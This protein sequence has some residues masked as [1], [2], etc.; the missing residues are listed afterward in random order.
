[1]FDEGGYQQ[2]D[3]PVGVLCYQCREQIQK[4]DRGLIRAALYGSKPDF[5]PVHTE[6][7]MIGTIGHLYG[8]CTCTGFDTTTRAAALELL[9]EVNARREL[10]GLGPL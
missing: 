3:T 9:R 1:M 10:G 4:D 7:E 5:L 2:V 8:V 6:C